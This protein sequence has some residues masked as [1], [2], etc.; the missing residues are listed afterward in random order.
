MV[1]KKSF[2]VFVILCG[3]F[4]GLPNVGGAATANQLP[5]QMN[6]SNNP[7]VTK[8]E[9][10]IYAKVKCK[11]GKIPNKTKTKC[12]AD[13]KVAKGKFVYLNTCSTSGCHALDSVKRF[14]NQKIGALNSAIVNTPEMEYLVISTT[15]LKNLVKYFATVK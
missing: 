8:A 7:R 12:V 2:A 4:L 10:D 13:P 5:R 1:Q 11:T 6:E 15:D 14:K 3:I 9:A